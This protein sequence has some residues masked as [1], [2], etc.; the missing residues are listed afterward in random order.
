V[1]ELF[2][3]V[4]RSLDRSQ[5]GLGIGLTLVKRLVTKHGGTVEAYSDGPGRGSEFVVR[6]PVLGEVP[7][8]AAA[9]P[10][11]RPAAGGCLRV[12]LVDDNT[13][14]ADSLAALVRLAGHEARVAHDGPGALE[15]AAAFRPQVVVLDIGLPG[16]TGYEV[17]RRLRADPDLAGA[18]LVAVTGYGRDEDRERARAAGFDHHL[19]KPVAFAE[20]L[21]LLTPKI[22]APAGR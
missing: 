21:G 5:G 2:T 3:Q 1:F 22:T 7:P 6:L 9:P 20:L 18:A 12:L 13:D 19:V 10:A 14:G 11:G 4:D 17:A 8:A 16:L 15:A